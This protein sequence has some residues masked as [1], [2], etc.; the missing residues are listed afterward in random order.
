MSDSN[1]DLNAKIG[2]DIQKFEQGIN[3]AIGSLNSLSEELNKIANQS[4]D[5]DVDNFNSSMEN[6]EGTVEDFGSTFENVGSKVN[7]GLENWGLNLNKFYDKGSSI[8]K[9]FGLDIDKFASHFGVNGKVIAGITACVVALEK[10]GEK[11]QEMTANIAKGTGAIGDELTKLKDTANDALINGVGRDASELGIM[12]AD[13]NTRFGYT[14]EELEKMT[15]EFDK[16]SKVT[17]SDV[18]SSI[19]SIADV[20]AKWNVGVE[21]TSAVMNQFARASQLSGASVDELMSSVKSSQSVFSQF[22]MSLT[23]SIAFTANLKKNGV[24]ASNAMIGMRTALAKFSAQGK[25]A[26]KGFEEVSNQ[27]RESKNETEAL[28][29]AIEIFGTRSGPEM[30][31]V[32]RNSSEEF[33]NL[34][35]SLMT[36]GTAIKDTEEASRT[37][38]DAIKDLKAT[39]MGTFGGFGEGI[40]NLFR[41]LIDTVSTLFRQLS[42][43]IRPIADIFKE[44]FSY[45]GQVIKLFAENLV[46]LRNTFS[47]TFSSMGTILVKVRDFFR[48]TF[49][50]LL[51]IIQ[52]V[53]GLIFDII[54]G[55]WEL[56]WERTK[57]I[58]M[59]VC[60]VILDF[61]SLIANAFVWMIN[62]IIDGLNLLIK[63]I[64]KLRTAMGKDE[65]GEIG[66][67][68]DVDI[69][70]SVGL[71]DALEES[72]K[73]IAEL[74]GETA[75]Q[76]TGDIGMVSDSILDLSDIAVEASE[77]EKQIAQEREEFIQ[78]WRDKTFKTRLQ[79]IEEEYAEELEKAE[80]EKAN[81]KDVIGI[82]K[83]Y[84]DKR[85]EAFTEMTEKERAMELERANDLKVDEETIAQINKFYDDKIAD[86]KIK[87]T[88]QTNKTIQDEMKNAQKKLIDGLKNTMKSIAKIIKSGLSFFKNV[89]DFN[90]DEALD[91]LLKFEDKILT[92]FV[93]TLPKLPGFFAS[94]VQSILV[95][96]NTLLENI[97]WDSI[98]D[99]LEKAFMGIV[100]KL[101]DIIS[102][103][104][105]IAVKLFTKAL[106]VILKGISKLITSI[107]KALPD[108]LKKNLPV[109]LNG[110]LNFIT[111]FFK[112]APKII[113]GILSQLPKIISGL[114]TGLCDFIRNL[115][116]KTIAELISAIIKGVA[117][118]AM[119]LI[120]NIGQ[121]VKELIPVIAN[122]LVELIKAIPD[123]LKGLVTGVWDGIVE[124]GK[125]AW[126]GIKN[127]GKGIAD[128]GKKVGGW[129]KDLF[130]GKLFAT[131]TNQAP[132]GLA[133]VGEAGPELVNFGGGEKV[134]NNTNT[135]K[136]LQNAGRGSVFNVTF[137]N[138]VDTTAYAMMKQLKGYQRSLAFNGII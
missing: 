69:S 107:L 96:I 125:S 121:I 38:S 56:A 26:S 126:E 47:T 95:L 123:I 21:N 75:Q 55:K 115:D 43:I 92:F 110:I 16:F 59:R 84:L 135:T 73:R 31:R 78:Q 50:D 51:K 33:D 94:A 41:D 22:G 11:M 42:P 91:D 54:N 137:E 18:K 25:N 97:D 30:L 19:N 48:G 46:K 81:L 71:T 70:K 118:L 132:K 57:N 102:K 58:L 36:S 1:F 79:Q 77:Q 100:E 101:P 44:I 136:I 90:P 120:K 83:E 130:T 66:H 134:Y 87:T 39:F 64:N 127:L 37:V 29:I 122:L 4:I 109:L 93:E 3:D 2:I 129:F 131:G 17:G 105:E 86:Y 61:V 116:G 27:I 80:L 23:D 9:N 5:T 85:L 63:Q 28:S 74:S 128:V 67:L 72:D 32:L 113:S 53:F 82:H 62:G 7:S 15:D 60:K 99:N 68:G 133:I 114:I 124:L 35:K 52:N 12:I 14:G 40:A 111:L 89:F 65:W 34:K 98:F 88:K 49:G 76:L 138:T 117:D 106:P 45:M 8:F 10:L 24:D 104:F 103:L 112:E 20:I 119:A 108:F 13:L 6:A